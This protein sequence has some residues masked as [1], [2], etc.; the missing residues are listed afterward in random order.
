MLGPF[1]YAIWVLA[2]ILE[3]SVVVCAI[4]R[5]NF[6]R[7]IT[8][9]VYML[10]TLAVQF[11]SYLCIRR[12]GI[13]SSEYHFLYYYTD[14]LM[15]ILMFFVIMQLYQQVFA[16]MKASRYIRSMAMALLLGTALFSYLVLRGHRA[17]LTDQFAIEMTQNLYFVGVVLTYVLWT[18]IF[19]MG[20]TRM[21]LVYFV[22]S[23]G[24]YFS[25][26]AGIFAFRNLFPSLKSV[27]IYWIPQ[28]LGAWLPLAWTYTLLRIPEQARFVG[29]RLAPKSS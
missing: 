12:Y 23:L 15:T 26:T 1:D 9:N 17:N 27:V 25:G 20:E 22:I 7:Y 19:K 11:V 6:L 21:R 4:Y 16:Q 8:L 29:A 3:I 13:S 18:A 14:G 5:G 2:A 24:I 10:G 28:I